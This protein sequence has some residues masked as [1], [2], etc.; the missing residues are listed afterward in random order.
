MYPRI[1]KSIR[2]KR[3]QDYSFPDGTKPSRKQWISH[4]QIHP[5]KRWIIHWWGRWDR[6]RIGL[7]IAEWEKQGKI[8]YRPRIHYTVELRESVR[9]RG[10]P[11]P[12]TRKV[13]FLKSTDSDRVKFYRRV[14]SDLL[15]LG[16]DS[17]EAERIVSLIKK[18]IET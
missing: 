8:V 15:T 14:T 12:R 18:R 7:E 4:G 2:P 1:K 3:K 17:A 5:D 13:W 16:I 9:V 6:A 11:T 10:K